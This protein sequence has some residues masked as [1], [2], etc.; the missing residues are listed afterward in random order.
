MT[1]TARSIAEY[2]TRKKQFSISLTKLELV[3]AEETLPAGVCGRVQGIAMVYDQVDFYDTIFARGCLAKSIVERVLTRKVNVFADHIKQVRCHVG[4]VASVTEIGDAVT[5]L[6]D[7]LDTNDGRSMLEYAKAC[8]AADIET[9]LSL[10]F[11]PRKGEVVRDKSNVPTGQ[12]KFTEIEWRETSITPVPAVPGTQITGARNDEGESGVDFTN[13]E[14]SAILA[15]VP[16]ERLTEVLTGLGF[17]RSS[18]N[19]VPATPAAPETPAESAPPVESSNSE[20]GTER[21]IATMDERMSA[22]RQSFATTR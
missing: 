7:L 8:I 9:G 21:K 2:S 12:Y 16:E 1:L 18:A 5:V 3:R 13:D 14:I 20:Q 6:I 4:V 19:A 17:S 11:I 15:A 22:L 10:G